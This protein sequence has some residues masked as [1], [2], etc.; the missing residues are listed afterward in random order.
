M[1]RSTLKIRAA[2]VI[3]KIIFWLSRVMR[4]IAYPVLAS[5]H[6]VKEARSFLE[7]GISHHSFASFDA[8]SHDVSIIFLDRIVE[9]CAYE[10]YHAQDDQDKG[11]SS[12]DHLRWYVSG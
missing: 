6:R 9:A 5:F 3:R 8:L 2:L 1:P 10:K 7:A 4:H 12:W 11:D